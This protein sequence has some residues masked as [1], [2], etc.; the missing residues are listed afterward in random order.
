[1]IPKLLQII[2]DLITDLFGYV[3]LFGLIY[4][5]NYF[6][7]NNNRSVLVISGSI[8]IVIFFAITFI[9]IKNTLSKKRIFISYKSN[10][11]KIARNIAEHLMAWGNE[12][13]FAE[14]YISIY[15]QPKN[16]IEELRKGLKRVK[17]GIVI[18]NKKYFQSSWCLEEL[19]SLSKN[20]GLD[21][22]FFVSTQQNSGIEDHFP[23]LDIKNKFYANFLDKKDYF[24]L[25]NILSR[26]S[27]L[28]YKGELQQEIFIKNNENKIIFKEISKEINILNWN[29]IDNFPRLELLN[30]LF[31]KLN[32]TVFNEMTAINNK[33]QWW[34]KANSGTEQLKAHIIYTKIPMER[35]REIHHTI[36][37]KKNDRDVYEQNIEYTKKFIKN[38]YHK[39]GIEY[40]ILGVHLYNLLDHT[41][42]AFTYKIDPY[43]NKSIIRRKYVL[44]FPIPNS[45]HDGEIVITVGFNHAQNYALKT[46]LRQINIFDAIPYSISDIND[47]LVLT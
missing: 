45:N 9:H 12:I 18:A 27:F 2:E 43:S 39:Y 33:E 8:L 3:F 24:K 15:N 29:R 21:N 5:V 46:F 16:F 6:F 10:D 30:W 31:G 1:M 7:I 47:S 14:Y 4:T 17:K 28:Y 42:F 32:P 22:L 34:F 38:N 41:H 13:W 25:Y 19:E 20:Q 26:N 11:V 23:G 37:S 40:E 35:T 36:V 44:T